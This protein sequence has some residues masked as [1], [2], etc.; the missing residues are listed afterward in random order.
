MK[1]YW[2]THQFQLT[3]KAWQIR[4]LL[5]QWTKAARTDLSVLEWIHKNRGYDGKRDGSIRLVAP[6]SSPL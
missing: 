5:D 4:I 3:G 1:S 2:S 6:E